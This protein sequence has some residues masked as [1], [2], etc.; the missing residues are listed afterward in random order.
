[1]Y[2]SNYNQ[3]PQDPNPIETTDFHV[4]DAA[5]PPKQK[6]KGLGVKIAAGCLAC[7]LVGGLAGG[8]VTYLVNG[9]QV[10]AAGGGASGGSATTIYEANR[11]TPTV[12]VSDVTGDTP[13]TISE[14][15]AANVNSTVGITTELVTTNFWGQPVS[16]A[17]AGSGFVISAD[18]YIV[19]NYHVVEGAQSIQVAFY[20]GSTYDAQLVGGEAD[21]DL[22]VLKIDATGLTP[23]TL[24]DSDALTVGE[25][26]AAIGNPLGELTFTLTSGYVSALNRPLTMSNGNVMNMIQTDTA[27][28][29]G[30][31][32]GPLFNIYGE[33]V[34]IT[35]AKLSNNNSS[36]TEATIE[37]LGFA[38]PINDVKGMI[39]DIIENGYVT[40]KAFMGIT[41]AEVS[42]EAVERYGIS[43]GV[44]VDGV[45]D[46]SAAAKA[47]IQEGDIITALGDTTVTSYN[48][49]RL[50]LRNYRAGDSVAVT[51]DRDGQTLTVN[52]TFD[53]APADDSTT[54]QAQSSSQP[55]QDQGG[56]YWPF[57]SYF[58]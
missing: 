49:L 36:S 4:H 55:Q 38:I 41:P 27:I 17:T 42:D 33:V 8:G 11:D 2:Y 16:A 23:V 29:N 47:G 25:Q 57:G 9:S 53:E 19:T 50:A 34:G 37:G 14:I 43:D 28:N 20:D 40:G 12:N 22:A 10:G 21:S 48:D 54:A 6:K 15:Y 44:Y 32:G 31:S 30:N 13:L 1:M 5:Q 3:T 24:G 18:G 26:V 39:T 58:G 51:I 56:S 46:G 7:A 52:I 45:T 35:S